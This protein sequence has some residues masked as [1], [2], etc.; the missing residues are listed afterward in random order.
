MKAAEDHLRADFRNFLYLVWKHLRLPPPTPIQYD[1][2]HYM[3][4]GPRRKLIMA[5][6]GV[7]KS[8]IY[9]AF[10]C[11][12]LYCDPERKIMVVSASRP[13]A[14]SF[15]TFVKR[16]INEMPELHHLR[17]RTSQRDSNYAFDVGPARASKDPSVKSVGLTGQITGSRADEI[18]ADD[19]EALNNSATQQQRDKIA[20]LIKEFEAVLKPDGT[21]CYL[22][23]PQTEDSIYNHL[24]ER[25]YDVRIWPAR[26]P[27]NAARYK[28]RLAPFI[29]NML[30][31]GVKPGTPSDPARFDDMDLLE[32]AASTG[33]SGF[34]LQYMLN[35]DLADQDRYPLKT[36]DFIVL[37]LDH[38]LGPAKVVWASG[39][40][41]R[42]EDLPRVGL[43]ADRWHR[44]LWISPDMVP[45]QGTVMAVDPS[46]RGRDETGYAVV[47][48]LHGMLFIPAAGGLKGGYS[49]ATLQELA[50]LAKLYKANQ[51]LVEANFGDGMFSSMLQPYLQKVEHR[52]A[53]LEVRHNTQKE[54]RIIDTLEPVLSSH[55]LIVDPKVIQDDFNS[56]RSPDGAS[57]DARYSLFY[58]LT[59][60]SRT[61]GC[62]AA[63]DRL[64]AL[65]MAVAHWT[66]AVR[67]DVDAAAEAHRREKLYKEVR[68]WRRK[69]GLGEQPRNSWLHAPRRL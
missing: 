2:A 41:H 20:E 23:T 64:D 45:W 22:G 13:I 62:L 11:W 27:D 21:I 1:I 69:H 32:R 66:E 47:R 67:K 65:A 26:V 55:R 6:R 43:G 51:I 19:V 15:S 12:R 33:R 24:P 49:E 39:P 53:M 18:L 48:C 10:T 36:S 60:V 8:W 37:S 58:Q 16:L 35:T 9:A 25:G 5:F 17:P 3:Q 30:D 59:R 61:K 68:A 44:P 4:H 42:C 7:G 63:D 56:A 57:A 14:D 50:R 29:V 54:L 52:A 40:D 34:S 46:G 38:T 28:G 31:K